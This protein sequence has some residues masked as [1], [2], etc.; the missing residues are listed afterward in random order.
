MTPNNNSYLLIIV[1]E[2]RI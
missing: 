2:L 1:I